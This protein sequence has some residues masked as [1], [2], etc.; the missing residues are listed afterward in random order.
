M[1]WRMKTLQEWKNNDFGHLDI[2]QVV[3]TKFDMTRKTGQSGL[4]PIL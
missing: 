1:N 4:F 2:R 3:M